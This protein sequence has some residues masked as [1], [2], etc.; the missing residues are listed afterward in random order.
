MSEKEIVAKE[1]M[2]DIRDTKFID[3]F[4]TLSY[5]LAVLVTPKMLNKGALWGIIC[6]FGI[7][8]IVMLIGHITARMQWRVDVW[9]GLPQQSNE[10]N[11]YSRYKEGL[12]YKTLDKKETI[13][14]IQIF[15]VIAA[16]CIRLK[17]L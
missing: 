9:R 10:F 15:A 3:W 2:Q 7:S 11:P 14:V 8:I 16:A 1:R 17:L 6:F 4:A 5:V 12:M 13:G